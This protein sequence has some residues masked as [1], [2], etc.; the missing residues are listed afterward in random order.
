MRFLY[1]IPL[2]LIIS[3]SYNNSILDKNDNLVLPSGKADKKSLVEKNVRFEGPDK[4]MYLFEIKKH[5]GP[6]LTEP[7]RYQP[8]P[9]DNNERV[10]REMKKRNQ[11][12]YSLVSR[13]SKNSSFSNYAQENATFKNR[14][15][16]NVP[17]R[18]MSLVVDKSDPSGNTWFV[19][20]VGGG[21]WKSTDRGATYIHIT[22]DLDNAYI[23]DIKQ[24]S[25][26]HNTM[27]AGAGAA[28]NFS[29]A[30]FSGGSLY[31]TIDG[32]LNWNNV[33]L[34]DSLGNVD[35]RFRSISRIDIDEDNDAI[36][37]VA[38]W[39]GSRW[40]GDGS[41][42]SIYRSEDG[43]NTWRNVYTS[44]PDERVTQLLSSP[45]DNKIKYASVSQLGVLKSIDGG[46]TWFNPGN[47]GL[48]GGI[49][50][51][52]EDGLYEVSYET[53]FER[54]EISVSRNNSNI[55]YMATTQNYQQGALGNRFSKL[56]VSYD[57]AKSWNYLRNEDG[58]V[59][60][61]LNSLGWFANS[62]MIH[63]FNDSIVYHGSQMAQRSKLLPDDGVGAN[64]STTTVITENTGDHF[65]INNV[66]GGS[67]IS[68][69]N[70][71]T[72]WQENS[73]NPKFEN[74]EIRF[75]PGKTQKAYRFTV[76]EGQGSGVLLE[77][78]TYQ[79]YVDVPFEVWN[80]SSNPPE[81]I[82]VSFRD[83]KNNGRFD[84][85]TDVN[86][87]REY[88]FI[89]NI[90]YDATMSQ[91][92]IKK[93]YGNAYKTTHLLWP[94]LPDGK[95]WVP[96]SIIDS[97]V[98]IE[99]IDATYKT[100]KKELIDVTD[101][102]NANILNQNVHVD[103]HLFDHI[104]NEVDST[105]SFIIGSDGGV[106]ISKP[107]KNPGIVDDDFY[108]AGIISDN[109]REPHGGFN[110]SLIWGADKVKGKDQYLMGAQD[111]GTFLSN[112][113]F[114]GSDTSIYEYIWSGDG[115]EVLAHFQDPN[116]MMGGSQGYRTIR[117]IDGGEEWFFV[118]NIPDY[119]NGPFHSR[120]DSPNQDPDV[121]YALSNTG[122]SK[123]PDW[124]DS[125]TE[126][127][128]ST[129]NWQ[130]LNI[131]DVKVSLANPRFVWAGGYMGNYSDI[132]LSTD[133][134][135]TFNP[136]N[137]F[138]NMGYISAIHTH[139]TEDSTAY[140]LFSFYGFTKIIETKDLGQSW[141]DITGFG[142]VSSGLSVSSK[143]FPNVAVHS[144][145]VMPHNTD[146]IWAGTDI[147][148]VESTDSGL[149][150][151]LVESNLPYVGIIDMKVKDQGQ[152]V[153]STYGRGI[154]TA[155]IEDLKTYEPKP[156]ILPP[157]ITNAKQIEDEILYIINTTVQYKSVYDSLEI[158]ANGT[159]WKTIRDSIKVETKDEIFN[160]DA[161]GN[162]KI[163][164]YG[165]KNGV[166]YASNIFEITLNPT[167]EPRTEYSTTFSDLVGDE[168]GL[169]RFRIGPQGGFEGRQLHTEHPYESGTAGGYDN[170]YSVHAQLNIPIIITDYTP[171]IRFKEIVL[172]EPGEPGSSYGDWNYWDYVIVEASKDGENWKRLIDG[173]DSDADPSWKS[174]YQSGTFGNPSLIRNRDIN[175][176]PHFNVGDTVKVRFRMFSDDLTVSWGWMV[177]DLYIQKD[178]PVV[179]GIEFTELDKNISIYPNPTE[180][181][182]KIEFEDTWQGEVVCKITDI[183]GRSIFRDILDNSSSNSSHEVDIRDS[184][185]GIYLV[186]LVQGDKKT[187]KKIIK[188]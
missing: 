40:F 7:S 63:P 146:I 110:T 157:Y 73:F 98:K 167:L 169:D 84:L 118:S 109:W 93:Q 94:Y 36:I 103:H 49:S 39:P 174:A 62:L 17:G 82:T 27:Y 136:V 156:A 187:M 29:S 42:G 126:A 21:I 4:A 48:L 28:W 132:V 50:Y 142:D 6:F 117:S 87:S 70:N 59:D 60:D 177:D 14:G 119:N 9:P 76:P 43:G 140:V 111:H 35:P 116:K 161:K 53:N 65:M 137:D 173:Y 80:T 47:L 172:V 95:F 12:R 168:F 176:S 56:Y 2:L 8:Y 99:N 24:S 107:S 100:L 162:Y 72:E 153:I 151:H 66:W 188:E 22:P 185:D 32:G 13:S 83:N 57:G 143:G 69:G 148:I 31:K 171:S 11:A 37:N 89:Q 127:N 145:L 90:P 64:G 178:L 138:A 5:G 155:T 101:S 34:K 81:Q 78:Y 19:G 74:I 67:R 108:I 166:S 55:L 124:G 158:T 182:F 160:V 134:G 71:S 54:L 180:G 38:T 165:Y 18:V 88:L 46:K 141:N 128:S 91:S 163:Q 1:I 75:G 122:I 120:Y 149:S 170:G 150:W 159:V 104:I 16:Y 15:P 92:Q 58:S 139:P 51:D 175:F 183:F 147:G 129:T 30:G 33:S 125:W 105:F 130:Q 112:K 61:W 86:E 135:E 85:T 114:I 41:R 115:F 164:A 181:E 102:Y 179:Q 3:C 52:N 26:N 184:N 106:N 45:S 96:S 23:T 20:A 25:Y 154:W 79:D 144:L 186:Q 123:S 133:W 10:L 77:Y 152:I 121:V 44:N 97:N 113:N 131:L 68:P